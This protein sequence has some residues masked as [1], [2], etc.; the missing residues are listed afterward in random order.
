MLLTI[1]IFFISSERT[2][3]FV[4][5]YDNLPEKVIEYA[6]GGFDFNQNGVDC[7]NSTIEDLCIFNNNQELNIDGQ[8]ILFVEKYFHYQSPINI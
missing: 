3:G 8:K 4:D 7:Q 6:L 1:I 5:R 2:S